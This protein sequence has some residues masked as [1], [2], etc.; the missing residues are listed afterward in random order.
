MYTIPWQVSGILSLI[1]G[2]NV[3]FNSI[4]I[5]AI[6]SRSME[7]MQLNNIAQERYYDDFNICKIVNDNGKI[8]LCFADE[9]AA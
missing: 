5:T 7:Y 9:E 3:V 1:A 4:I 6:T 2:A 8:T